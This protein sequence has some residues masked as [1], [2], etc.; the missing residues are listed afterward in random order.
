MS[1]ALAL[2]AKEF[3]KLHNLEKSIPGC[4]LLENKLPNS[5]RL[6]NR[7]ECETDTE[8]LQL[9]PYITIT[10]GNKV[11]SYKR[12]NSCGESRLTSKYSIGFGGH[13]DTVPTKGIKSHIVEEAAREL[14]EELS[15]PAEFTIAKLE[16]AL[17]N[18]R[19]IFENVSEV[20]KV[21]VG[22]SLIVDLDFK[23]STTEI[24]TITKLKWLDI[25]P[26]TQIRENGRFETW[27]ELVSFRLKYEPKPEP[28]NKQ[29]IPC[30]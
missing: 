11:L 9:I 25:D 20:G 29:T 17:E 19:V 8:W 21:H 16:E 3:L 6:L 14:E 2:N 30:R 1:T 10:N 5:F 4:Y 12:G 7:P 22:L 24:D 15:L 27:S 13:I 26:I 28:V 18:A 23:E